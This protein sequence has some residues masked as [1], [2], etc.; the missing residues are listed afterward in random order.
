MFEG[1]SETN[2]RYW[3]VRGGAPAFIHRGSLRGFSPSN[4]IINSQMSVVNC[5]QQIFSRYF[6]NDDLFNVIVTGYKT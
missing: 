3:V 6:M 4:I 5:Q 2:R 1:D